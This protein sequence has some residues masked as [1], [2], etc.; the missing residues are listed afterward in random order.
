MEYLN[1]KRD[2]LK[3]FAHNNQEILCAEIGLGNY[4]E[5][6]KKYEEYEDEADYVDTDEIIYLPIGYTEE[7]LQEF[8]AKLDFDYDE[9]N[10][11]KEYRWIYGTVWAKSDSFWATRAEFEMANGMYWTYPK[12]PKIPEYLRN[13]SK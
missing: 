10:Y 9:D 11:D 4:P 3:I 6:I 7:Q 12:M 2:L 8:L 13:Q 5:Y 1:A